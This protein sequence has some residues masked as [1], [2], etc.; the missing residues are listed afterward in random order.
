VYVSDR[1]HRTG[2]AAVAHPPVTALDGG[3]A[4]QPVRAH[5]AEPA[6]SLLPVGGGGHLPKL[7]DYTRVAKAT[8]RSRGRTGTTQV[9]KETLPGAWPYDHHGPCRRGCQGTLHG[10]E[11]G[12]SEGDATTG[13]ARDAMG[14]RSVDGLGQVMSGRLVVRCGLPRGVNRPVRRCRPSPCRG[15][16]RGRGSPCPRPY[17]TGVGRRS[18]APL[19]PSRVICTAPCPAMRSQASS[20]QQLFMTAFAAW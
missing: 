5:D 12:G 17:R 13:E 7:S 20:G 1:G 6:S 4:R 15:E 16:D 2:I 9:L 14:T 18:S 8:T 3:R 19:A 11:A 10:R